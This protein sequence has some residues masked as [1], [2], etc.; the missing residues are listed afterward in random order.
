M[1]VFLPENNQILAIVPVYTDCGE[2]TIV[3]T[4]ATRPIVFSMKSSTLIKRLANRQAVDLFYLKASAAKLTKSTLCQPLPL[5]PELLL[6]P[7]KTRKPKA[8]RDST[9]G[10]LNFYEIEKSLHIANTT[11]VSFKNGFKL[12]VLWTKQTVDNHLQK[13]HLTA[14]AHKKCANPLE[15]VTASLISALFRQERPCISYE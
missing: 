8:S 1:N 3:Y 15:A 2:Q 13:A 10:Y 6:V 7:V 9:I 5:S 11:F 14:L 4:K 12:P